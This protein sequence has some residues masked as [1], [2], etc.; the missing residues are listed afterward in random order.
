[1]KRLIIVLAGA[2][3]AVGLAAPA[4]ADKTDGEFLNAL[5]NGGVPYGDATDAISWAHT[6][7]AFID[8]GNR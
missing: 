1:M 7:C 2:V 8:E 3:A 5:S 6:L 4:S